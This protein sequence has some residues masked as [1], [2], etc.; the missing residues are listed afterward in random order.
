M[1]LMTRLNWMKCFGLF[2]LS[3]DFRFL[4]L[5]SMLVQHFWSDLAFYSSFFLLPFFFF[6]LYYGGEKKSHFEGLIQTRSCPRKR[7]VRLFRMCEMLLITPPPPCNSR[8]STWLHLYGFVCFFLF[9][10]LPIRRFTQIRVGYC[11][12]LRF[13]ADDVRML[14]DWNCRFPRTRE[15][16]VSP[17]TYAGS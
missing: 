5:Q 7:S 9:F 15:R 2:F 6:W 17:R 4:S 10:L 3:F 11:R 13:K 14:R 1:R 12:R 8:P 16:Q